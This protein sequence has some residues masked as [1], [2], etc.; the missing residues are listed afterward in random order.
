M[1]LLILTVNL[2]FAG[3]H[4]DRSGLSIP[5]EAERITVA[6]TISDYP[7]Y[8]ASIPQCGPLLDMSSKKQAAHTQS[9]ASV[10]QDTSEAWNPNVSAPLVTP[11]GTMSLELFQAECNSMVSSRLPPARCQSQARI[12][13]NPVTPMTN[14]QKDLVRVRLSNEELREVPAAPND[15][16]HDACSRQPEALR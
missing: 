9:T 10:I 1:F 15:S 11:E 2:L 3:I 13:D 4:L 14:T 6:S 16:E 7:V 8:Q 5:S 12:T